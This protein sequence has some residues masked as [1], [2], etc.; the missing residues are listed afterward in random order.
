MEDQEGTVLRFRVGI[1][2]SSLLILVALAVFFASITPTCAVPPSPPNDTPPSLFLTPSITGIPADGFS[3]STINAS[4]WDGVDW[5]WFGPA[6]NFSTDLGEINASALIENGTAKAILT[7]GTEPGVATI[8]AEAELSG[9]GLVTNTTTVNF[10]VTEFDTGA[11]TYPSISGVHEGFIVPNHTVIVKKLY[12]YPCAGTGGHAE[13][14]AFYNAET[15]EE[16]AN[17]TWSGYQG[18]YH[19]LTFPEQFTLEEGEEYRYEI[20]TGSYPQIIHKHNCTTRDGSFINC[21]SF[22]DLNGNFYDDWIP[23]FRLGR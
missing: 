3:T 19:N 7:A 1:M 18:D 17:A 23:A 10:T 2:L 20:V 21:T 14:A 22:V 5:I 9:I 15:E 4:V 12:T 6:V 11:G 13:S 16:I 8:T